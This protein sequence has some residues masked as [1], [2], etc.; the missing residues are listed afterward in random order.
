MPMPSNRVDLWQ[1]R[2]KNFEGVRIV[3]QPDRDNSQSILYLMA[4]RDPCLLL[5][6]L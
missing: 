5:A 4:R 3:R 6:T 1:R 2:S